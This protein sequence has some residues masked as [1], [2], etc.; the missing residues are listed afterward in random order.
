MMSC[1]YWVE[2]PRCQIVHFFPSIKHPQDTHGGTSAT[3]NIH[4]S[5]YK[6]IFI[7]NRRLKLTKYQANAKQHPEAE[8]LTFENYSDSSITL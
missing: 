5:H 2:R 3:S 1:V 7:S 8:L 4:A 6:S